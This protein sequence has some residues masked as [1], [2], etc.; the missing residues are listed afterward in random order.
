MNLRKTFVALCL[1]C[2]GALQHA[3]AGP[4][5][6]ISPAEYDVMNVSANGKWACG[7]YTDYS[8]SYYAF[9]WNLETGVTELLSTTEQSMAYDIADDGTVSGLFQDREASASGAPVELPGYYRDGKW[10]HIEMPADRTGDGIAGGISPDGHYMVAS[11]YA[12]GMYKPYMW[13]DGKICRELSEGRQGVAYAVSADGKAATGWLY[14]TTGAKN[15]Q[16]V[17]WTPEGKV[18][19]L[20]DVQTPWSYGRNFSPNGQWLVYWGGWVDNTDNLACIYEI[21]TGKK[22]AIP[23]LSGEA[24]FEL[25]DI[26]N[27]GT[28]VGEESDRAY[29]YIGGKGYYLDEWLAERGVDLDALGVAKNDDGTYVFQ[30]A[31]SISG[32]GNVVSVR[33]YD[34]EYSLR[35][36]IVMLNGSEPKAPLGVKTAQLPGISAVTVT[37]NAPVGV[38]GLKGYNIYRNGEKVNGEPVSALKYNDKVPEYGSYAYTVG[39]VYEGQELKSAEAAIT[40]APQPVSVPQAFFVRQK[41]VNGIRAQWEAP[42]S[43]L[44]TRN[45]YDLSTANKQGFGVNFTDF[46]FEVAVGFDADEMA[47][48]DGCKIQKVA[49]YPMCELP[50]WAINVYSYS[51]DGSLNLVA[52]Q[53]I[54]QKLTYGERNIVTLDTP[55]ALPEG[56]LVVAIQAQVGQEALA[57]IIGMDYGQVTEGYS[58]LLRMVGEDDFSSLGEISSANGVAMYLSW[59]IDVMLAPDGTSG[60]VDWVN[61]YNVYVDGEKVG[62]TTARRY[63]VN[64]LADGDHTVAVDAEFNIGTSAKVEATQNVKAQYVGVDYAKIDAE[65]D[66]GLVAEWSAP[67]DNDRTTM[68]YAGGTA[69]AGPS[70]PSS[71]NYGLMAGAQYIP[72]L[73]KGYNGYEITSF[74]FYPTADAFFTFMLTEDDKQI[75]EVEV[76]DFVLNQWNTVKLPEPIVIN[77]NSTYLLML[78]CYD[79]ETET[80]NGVVTGK[81]PL[82]IDNTDPYMFY[83]DLYS[84]DGSSWQSLSDISMYGNWMIGWEMRD[85]YGRFINVDGYD[86]L[87]D[88][89]KAN[90]ARLSTTTFKHE[91]AANDGKAHTLQVDTYYPARAEAVPGKAMTFYIGVSGIDN[92]TVAVLNMRGDNNRLC[93]EG[94]GVESLTAYSMSGTAVASAAGNTL[95]ISHLSSGVY[96][97]KV[98]VNGNDV[99]R[100][101]EVRR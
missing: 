4:V 41:G 39:A 21:P 42:A 88:G 15:R 32:D 48:Y 101:I 16:A 27:D 81:A 30:W 73:L 95:D 1:F 12:G 22:T 94:D 7:M 77:E 92:A 98:K 60:G 75:A 31:V 53:P 97:V 46:S 51:A 76:D 63:E 90:G 89:T 38:E 14:A 69:K 33:Y 100:K 3:A 24:E 64:D 83:S 62:S 37:W 36:M 66:K 5:T 2:A 10:H 93:V 85:P 9:R 47:C 35:T 57:R 82:A 72:E 56:K 91:F 43:N 67:W 25:T 65:G 84:T 11:V 61:A 20:S 8:G 99:T 44:I 96:V 18:V 19:E 6:L 40:V 71:N 26:S 58:D 17:Y 55:V 68:S 54:T 50:S 74:R 78:D 59:M 34:K 45:W 29:I 70:G 49:F 13:K 79:V 28:A 52:T 87:I 80:V 23:V 86:V